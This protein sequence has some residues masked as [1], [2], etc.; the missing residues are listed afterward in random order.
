SEDTHPSH[1]HDHPMTPE[2]CLSGPLTCTPQDD[3]V[4]VSEDDL[5]ASLAVTP[6][7]RTFVTEWLTIST[8]EPAED[9]TARLRPGRCERG[10]L[11]P[12]DDR[13]RRQGE[14]RQGA[15]GEDPQGLQAG[16]CAVGH[17]CPGTPGQHPAP[18]DGGGFPRRR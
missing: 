9:R 4:E 18:G 8:D 13:D 14:V 10:P 1:Q 17:H 7:V 2:D 16:G 5:N 3:R 6:N 11:R 15:A 12:A